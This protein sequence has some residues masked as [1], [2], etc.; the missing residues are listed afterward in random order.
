MVQAGSVWYV[1]AWGIRSD[2]SSSKM[3]T[4][5][6]DV[7]GINAIANGCSLPFCSHHT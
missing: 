1:A 7:E 5:A 3:V 4:L 6:S 2:R